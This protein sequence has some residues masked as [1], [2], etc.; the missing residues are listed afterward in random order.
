MADQYSG[1]SVREMLETH[2]LASE[3]IARAND[4]NPILDEH[5]LTRLRRY[6][7]GA[8]SPDDILAEI[9]AEYPTTERVKQPGNGSLVGFIV[10]QAAA[11]KG[12]LSEQEVKQLEKWFEE[13]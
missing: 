11:G 10:A 3:I 12:I 7:T 1:P 6:C 8:S 2:T 5:E 4:P 9:E 13:R